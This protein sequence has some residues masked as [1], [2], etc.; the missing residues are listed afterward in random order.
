MQRT[1]LVFIYEMRN[2]IHSN[3][4]RKKTQFFVSLLLLFVEITINFLSRR[5]KFCDYTKSF[6]KSQGTGTIT[7]K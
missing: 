6:E 2:H 3:K 1:N 4:E 7:V 5:K